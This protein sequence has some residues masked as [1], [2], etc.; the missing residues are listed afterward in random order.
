MKI[1]VQDEEVNFNP[2]EEIKHSKDKR[3]RFKMDF[4]NE[5]NMYVRKQVHI[6][7]SL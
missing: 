5:A 3:V 2:F 1:R 7:T 4:T 6:P